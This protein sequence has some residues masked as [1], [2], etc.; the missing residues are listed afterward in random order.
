MK[1]ANA[2]AQFNEQEITITVP[3]SFDA[4]AQRLTLDAASEAGFPEAV[5]LLEEPQAAFYCWLEQHRGS[6]GLW[7]QIPGNPAYTV[8]CVDI[9]RCSREFA[10][11]LINRS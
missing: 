5:R 8:L 3:A 10:L 7:G 1:F 2:G 11:L 4:A 6:D 9:G